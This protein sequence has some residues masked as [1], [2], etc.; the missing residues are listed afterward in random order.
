MVVQEVEC[1][2]EQAARDGRTIEGDVFFRQ[3]QTTDPADEDGRIRVQGIGL[4]LGAGVGDGAVD[5]IAQV[6]LPLD[7][8]V[9]GRRQ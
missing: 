7:H 4:A 5:R 6:D 3:V 1:K 8:L 9:P 2:V